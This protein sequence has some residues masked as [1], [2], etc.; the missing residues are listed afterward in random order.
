MLFEKDTG[1]VKWLGWSL[2]GEALN[3]P[4]DSP[5]CERITNE[6][7]NKCKAVGISFKQFC[8]RRHSKV[9]P[10][11]PSDLAPYDDDDI[12]GEDE[13]KDWEPPDLSD[14]SE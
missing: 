5:A 1:G 3:A 9:K 6:L 13:I 10:V 8:L 2:D 11:R 14:G 12:Y 4:V 7:L